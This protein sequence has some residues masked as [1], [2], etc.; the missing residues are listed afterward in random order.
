MALG[1]ALS[2]ANM[3]DACTATSAGEFVEDGE[4]GGSY[5]DGETQTFACRTWPLNAREMETLVS[6]Q[7]R[8]PG[9]EG[10]AYPLDVSL[11]ATDTLA[12]TR[13]GSEVERRYEVKGLIPDPS[14]VMH[15]R[16]IIKRT[17]V[18]NIVEAES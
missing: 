1:R 6:D 14:Y 7:L 15:R 4:G 16:A 12:I 8:E 10:L 18:E 9:L 17:N 5:G 13:E 11:S 2:A 3:P